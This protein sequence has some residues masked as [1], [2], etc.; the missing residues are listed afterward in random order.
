VRGAKLTADSKDEGGPEMARAVFGIHL[1]TELHSANSRWR[2]P[3][4][5]MT[6]QVL[7]APEL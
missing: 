5:T 1:L 3:S 6:Y 7:K 2:P 4:H